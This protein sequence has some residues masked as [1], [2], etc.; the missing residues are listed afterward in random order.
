[1]HPRSHVGRPKNAAISAGVAAGSA[2]VLSAPVVSA[3]AP[4]SPDRGTG[5]GRCG[6][7]RSS[8]VWAAVKLGVTF[9]ALTPVNARSEPLALWT[10]NQTSPSAAAAQDAA[11]K[12]AAAQD[13]T[14][15]KKG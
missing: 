6:G 9:T 5:S 7:S 11:A 3:P 12:D 14:A 13:A 10:M 15:G 8:A 2:L 4:S 1:M